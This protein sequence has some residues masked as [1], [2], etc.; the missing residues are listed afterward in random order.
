ML[1]LRF[2][3]ELDI[4][5]QELL[6]VTFT[7]AATEELKYRV[8]QRMHAAKRFLEGGGDGDSDD[9]LKRWAAQLEI[10]PEVAKKRLQMA[11]L[12]IDQA[13]VLTIHGFCQRILQ[14]HALESGQLFDSELIGDIS[15][16]RQ[17][18]ADDYWR[19]QVYSRKVWEAGALTAELPTPDALLNSIAKADNFTRVEPPAEPIEQL[20]STVAKAAA[21][22][23]QALDENAQKLQKPLADG[24]FKAQYNDF[25]ADNLQTLQCWLALENPVPPP[26]DVLGLLSESGLMAALNGQKFRTT[27]QQ[28]GERRK[29]Q[30]LQALQITTQPFDELLMA[31]AQLTLGFRRGLVAYLSDELAQRLQ[32]LNM[33]SFDDLIA[34]L[35]TV[36]A[37]EMA[38]QLTL[39]LQQRF[40]VA[41]IDEFQD[42]DQKQWRI[43]SSLFATS[44]HYLYLIGDPKQA[45]YKFRGADIFSYFDALEQAGRHYTLEKNWRS[46]PALVA[47]INHLFARNPRPFL[48]EQ[49]DFINVS[50]ARSAGDGCLCQAGREVAPMVL[51]QLPENSRNNGFWSAGLAADQIMQAVANEV[52]RLLSAQPALEIVA[53]TESRHLLAEDIAILVRSNKQ[54]K[55]Y[56]QALQEQGVPAVLNSTESVFSSAEAQ[57]LYH[58]LQAIAQP[59]NPALLKQ[60]LTLPWFGLD[61]Q[62]YYRT[63]NDETA[64][65]DWINCFHGYY[66][67]WSR[68][69][70]MAMMQQLLH[71]QGLNS[72]I[73]RRPDAERCLTNLYHLLELLQQTAADEHLGINKTLDCLHAGIIDQQ[74]NEASQLRLE[75]DE[76]SVKIITLHRAKGLEYPVVFC[77]YL[78]QRSARLQKQ[79]DLIVCHDGGAMLADLGSAD[80]E[81]RRRLAQQEELAEDLRL[82]YVALTRAKYRCY[83]VWGDV[84]TKENTNNSALAYLLFGTGAGDPNVPDFSGQQR[85][86]Q[87]FNKQWPQRFNYRLLAVRQQAEG[88]YQSLEVHHRLGVKKLMRSLYSHW[89]MSSYTALSGLTQQEM[90]PELPEDKAQEPPSVADAADEWL[91]RGALTGNVVHELL[92]TIDFDR[93][94]RAE[95]ISAQREKICRRYGLQLEK[96]A[97]LDD[98]LNQVVTTPLSTQDAHFQLAS[99][100]AKQCLKEMPFYLALKTTEISHINALLADCTAYQ[101]L[102]ARQISGYLTGFIDLICVYRGRYYVMD[103]KTNSLPDYQQAGLIQ[104]MHEHNYGLQYWLYSLVL[105]QYLA[106]RLP[107]YDYHRHFGGVRY[108]FVRGMQPRQPGSAVFSDRPDLS[109]LR[110]LA[111]LF[112]A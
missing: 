78:W 50:A 89:Q 85:L 5:V 105:H 64:L 61:G 112:G 65:Y 69:G 38:G 46:H 97:L 72:I 103:Y 108:L 20:L 43:F 41:L 93:L 23:L 71:Q 81:R 111:D 10:A 1:A 17:Q 101:A 8:R 21:A 26:R 18:I 28:S 37:S 52:V 100:P 70:L 15:A 82:L 56:Q 106:Q 47:D 83:M 98:L 102:T 39:E 75:S 13:P 2:V 91:P 6:I 44:Q 59:G 22:A 16:L 24:F 73:S 51:W 77:P 58:L 12:D 99:L 94:S 3:V 48:F 68:H 36:L 63:I 76:Q 7:R 84:R 40:K 95:D 96:P 86:L 66:Q 14:E 80:F 27:Q 88:V 79:R 110:Q 107:D 62:D 104:A 54:A 55:L 53:G 35:C 4:P 74:D 45:V 30:F 29:Q 42:T 34:R 60:A 11:L 57:V 31:M 67:Y 49:L 33:L 109:R 19:R 92:E 32:R 9:D 90:L 87:S 25:F